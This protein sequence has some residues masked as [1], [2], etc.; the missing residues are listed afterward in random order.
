MHDW[1]A[2]TATLISRLDTYNK[3]DEGTET[4]LTTCST[5]IMSLVANWVA[6]EDQGKLED[7]LRKILSDA[8]KLSQT[9]HCQ[10][11]L[12]SIRQAGSFVNRTLNAGCADSLL[13]FDEGTMDDNDGD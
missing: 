7:G 3:T 6:V 11:A 2:L 9:L 1:R 8:V 10:R 13:Y 5:R 4:G 12:W